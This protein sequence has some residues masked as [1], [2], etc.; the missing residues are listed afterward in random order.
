MADRRIIA[1]AVSPKAYDEIQKLKGDRTWTD[2]VIELALL[3]NPQNQV[4]TDEL[5]NLPKKEVKEQKPKAEKKAK[6]VKKAEASGEDK[7][8]MVI[9]EEHEPTKE[10]LK[11]IETG[12][13][14]AEETERV[15]VED[16]RTLIMPHT[17]KPKKGK[18]PAGDTG[19]Q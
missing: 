2:Y 3:E 12:V 18:T 8:A 15:E 14:S 1:I 4:L 10:E 13:P 19:S 5:A 17:H 9:L 6:K 11:A 16:G 7:V